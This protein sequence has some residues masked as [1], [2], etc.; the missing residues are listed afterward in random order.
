M[1]DC[2]QCTVCCILPKI[3]EMDSPCGE[4]CKECIP[5]YGCKIYEDRPEPCKEFQCA[6]SQMEYTHIDLRPD[7]CGAMFE[8]INGTLILGSVTGRLTEMPKLIK[9]QIK[10][11]INEGISVMMQQFNPHKF[12]CYMVKG[13]SREKIQKALEEKSK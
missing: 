5:N 4:Y 12:V 7:N 1:Q 8:K 13:A 6:W 9:N 11:F 2:G 3:L 10:F